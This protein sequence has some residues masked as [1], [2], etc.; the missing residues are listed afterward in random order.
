[1]QKQNKRKS[2]AAADDRGDVQSAD[3]LRATATAIL[4]NRGGA[5]ARRNPWNEKQKQRH[6]PSTWLP[7]Q[8]CFAR[9][10]PPALGVTDSGKVNVKIRGRDPSCSTVGNRY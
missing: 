10:G 8:A 3:A 7:P 1:M 4:S 6:C 2:K 5:E 9:W